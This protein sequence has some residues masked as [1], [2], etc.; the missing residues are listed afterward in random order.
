[1]SAVSRAVEE[2]IAENPPPL[3]LRHQWFGLTYINVI[4]Q[5]KMVIGMLQALASGFL[6]VLIIMTLLLRSA[7]WGVLAMV[8]LTLTIGFI[9]GVIGIIGK[10]YDMPVAL[11]SSLALGLAVDFSIHFLV[12]TRGLYKKSES[13][14]E[15]VP[16]IFGEP[17]RAI[18]R[19]I[20]VVAVGFLPLLAAPLVPYNTVG[21]LIAAILVVSGA[22]TLLLLPVLLKMFEPWLFPRTDPNRVTA[23]GFGSGVFVAASVALLVSI[24]LHQFA[25]MD[26]ALLIWLPI[27]V[28]AVAFG[29][30]LVNA[31]KTKTLE[32]RTL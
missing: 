9:Y 26:W 30:H 2:F 7:A 12:R 20:V 27:L 15:L 24:N 13:W 10:D 4:W 17:A 29:I 21:I 22:V 3:E 16:K 23:F 18:A 31:R 11:L 6:F 19:N 5:E 1:M 25:G 8:P 32:E 14:A 28:L